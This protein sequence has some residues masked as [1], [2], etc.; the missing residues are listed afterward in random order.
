M[1]LSATARATRDRWA[2]IHAAE[3]IVHTEYERTYVGQLEARLAEIRK[4]TS[5]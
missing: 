5:R 4:A 1:K 3:S 2:V